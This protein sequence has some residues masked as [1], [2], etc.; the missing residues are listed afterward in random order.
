MFDGGYYLQKC[1][2]SMGAKFSPSLANLY[3]G[4]WER[5][6]IFGHGSPIVQTPIL[7]Y[8]YIDDLL[9]ITSDDKVQLDTWLAYLNE[10]DLNL[11]F[12]GLSE[13]NN[14]VVIGLYRKPTAGN[15]LLRADSAHPGHTNRGVPFAQFLRLKRLCSTPDD[16][17][18]GYRHG[19]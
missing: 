12:T 11:R 15:A 8:R 4:W 7:F 2:T 19:P 16:F 18:R 13:I 3:M 9:F 1:G 17:N 10:N 6:R 5:S 14:M